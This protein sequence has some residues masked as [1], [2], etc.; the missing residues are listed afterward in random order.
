MLFPLLVG[1]F[2]TIPS[3]LLIWMI[4]RSAERVRGG[5]L[6]RWR[7]LLIPL[8]IVLFL[9]ANFDGILSF[10]SYTE[11]H[12][13]ELPFRYS[14][15]QA[16]STDRFM[17]AGMIAAALVPFVLVRQPFKSLGFVLGVWAGYALWLM[18]PF[19]PLLLASGVPFRE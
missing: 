5:R 14:H 7:R 2:V 8:P 12:Q 19:V 3:T 15:H 16:W 1:L 6:S 17:Y 11:T 4:E 18:V 10:L 13:S 9:V